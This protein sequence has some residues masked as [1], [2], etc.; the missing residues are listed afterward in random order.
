MLWL[1]LL[2][3]WFPA[4][5]HA[6]A[7]TGNPPFTRYT[8]DIEVYPQ[9][10]AV[11]EDGH[12]IIYLGSSEGVLS[13]DGGHWK[14]ITL[15]NHQWVRSLAYDG[16]ERIYVGGYGQFGYIDHDAAGQ[17]VFHDLTPKFA[18]LLHGEPFADIWSVEITPIGVVFHAVRHLFLYNPANGAVKLWRYDARY[19]AVGFYQGKLFAQFRGEGLKYLDHDT[20]RLLPDGAALPQH[21]YAAIPLDDGGL[22]FLSTSGKWLQYIHGKVQSFPVPPGFPPSSYFSRGTHLPGGTIVLTTEDGY[23]YFL[24]SRGALL[25]KMRVD[26]GYLSGIVRARD[27]GLLIS[28]DQAVIHVAWPAAWTVLDAEQGLGGGMIRTMEWGS[29]WFVMT[30]AGVY[31]NDG[32]DRVPHFTHMSWSSHESFDLLPLDDDTALLADAYAVLE[33]HDNTARPITHPHLYPRL[34]LR[35]RYNRNLV[36]I[37]TELGLATLVNENGQWKLRLDQEDMG[38]PGLNSLVEVAPHT[39]WVGSERGGA[40][41][42]TLSRDDSRIV[43]DRHMGATE[44]LHYGKTAENASVFRMPDDSI[45]VSTA[46]GEFRWKKDKFEPETFGNL[47]QLRNPDE[48]LV[49]ALAGKTLWA[50]DYDRVF[51]RAAQG[52]DW[53]EEDITSIRHGAA[54]Q[55]ITATEGKGIVL[56]SNH[57]ILCYRPGIANGHTAHAQTM[58]RSVL[59]THADGSRQYL[60][61][62]GSS[63]LQLPQGE[64]SLAFS[65]TLPAY[66]MQNAVRYRARLKGFESEF[67]DW[68]TSKKY[69]YSHLRPITYTFEVRGRDAQGRVTETQ[70]FSF[71]IVPEWYASDWARG[72]LIALLVLIGIAGAYG[73]VRLRTRRLAADK[74]RLERMV[75]ERTAE[76]ETANRKLESMAHL[77]GL[78]GIANRRRLDTYLEQVWAQCIERKRALSLLVIDV[79][80]FKQY[81]DRHGHLAG[82]S[83]LKRLV[84]ILSRCLRR[85]EDLLARYGGEEF[86]VVLPGAGSDSAQALAEQMRVQVEATS[87]GATISV[88][89]ATA[90][91]TAGTA[92]AVLVSAAD[93]AL[94]RAKAAGRNRTVLAEQ[95]QAI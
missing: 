94:Y 5:G 2:P 22:L 3:A 47:A 63:P 43:N 16:G 52:E 74:T 85:T 23:L 80:H 72:L 61:L 95:E 60:P 15:P 42:V 21:A 1:G 49:F 38:Q 36:Y 78:T 54:L 48:K 73:F 71:V 10:F 4:S 55:T 91:P 88:G 56:V 34:F 18:N 77:D 29:R 30:G 79:D 53:Q 13:F 76:L 93:A 27:G 67:S 17:P 65:F 35:S 31:A 25:W 39:L 89:V 62:N 82:D 51:R 90:M 8:P 46:V 50:F 6:A 11:A 45:L 59:L 83:L 58:L 9:N 14:L 81:N 12:S 28:G 32:A 92:V 70:P 40:H 68:S 64:F 69:T 87:L 26:D 57:A 33:I 44:G 75:T 7:L 20:W 37:G 86:L 24:S 66:A 19:G 84:A 41:L